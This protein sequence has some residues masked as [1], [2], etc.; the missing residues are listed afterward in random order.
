MQKNIKTVTVLFVAVSA[1][2]NLLAF[3]KLSFVVNLYSPADGVAW[4]GYNALQ[5]LIYGFTCFLLWYFACKTDTRQRVFSAVSGFVMSSLTVSGTYLH[6]NN[7]LFN[8]FK[9]FIS[10][11]IVILGISICVIPLWSLLMGQTDR[12]SEYLSLHSKEEVK[13]SSRGNARYFFIMWGVI[14]VF[15]IPVLLAW[16]PGNFIYDAA[17][18]LREYL[19]GT[20]STH[21]PLI[22]TLLMAGCYRIGGKF[23]GSAS[24]GFGMYTVFQMLVITA[25]FAYLMWMFKVNKVSRAIRVCTFLWITLFPINKCFAVTATKDVLCGGFFLIF[26]VS[27]I[28]ILYYKEHFKWY[29]YAIM[30]LAGILSCMFRNNMIYAIVSGGLI[31]LCLQKGIRKKLLILA[32]ICVIFIGQKGGNMTLKL[33]FHASSP[34][35]MRESLSVPLQCLARVA[36]Y[37]RNDISDETYEEIIMYIPK[38]LLDAGGYNPYNSDP[39]KADANEKLLRDNFVNFVKLWV[40]VG[41]KFPGE[42]IESFLT[43][44][45]AYWYP[46]NMGHYTLQDFSSYHKLIYTGDEIEKTSL[47]PRFAVDFYLNLYYENNYYKTPLLGFFFRPAPY[48]WIM[49]FGIV[50]GLY[51]RNFR[52]MVIYAIPFMYFGTCF[53]GPIV[54]LRYIYPVIT[55]IPLFFINRAP[56]DNRNK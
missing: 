8:D 50:Y 35:T 20:L 3:N 34:D 9:S 21:H 32:A 42:Y 2:L 28:R 52:K 25:A 43:N 56:E 53:M 30:L 10:L 24:L 41:L 23:L 33:A 44:T 15:F 17:D 27:L 29:D 49:M 16:W 22:H 37:R 51:K 13:A 45:L 54:A 7:N 40:K 47:L 55:V 5:L 19:G 39:V 26:V 6:F 14:T 48:F 31:I 12:I 36:V 46:D 1:Y 11:L 18:Q 38:D 4:F